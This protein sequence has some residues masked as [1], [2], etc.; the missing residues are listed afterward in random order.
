MFSAVDSCPVPVIARVQGAALGGGTGLAC[1]CDIVLAREDARFGF[2]EVRLGLVP[3]TI[4][5]FALARIGRSQA[6]ALFL[7][8]ELFDAAHALRIGLAHEVHPDDE[9][10]DAAVERVLAAVLRGGPEAVRASKALDRRS[11]RRRSGAAVGARRRADR[12]AARL[13]RGP[14][15]H[16]RVPGAA[17]AR[18]VTPP[19]AC[20]AVACRGEIALRIIRACREVGSQSLALV[21]ADERGGIAEREADAAL[22]VDSYLD[23]ATLA[24][25]AAAGGAQ[26]LHP[27]YG[28]LSE[29]PELAEAC[30][31]AGLVFVGPSSQA[32]ATLGRKDAAREL[33]QRAGV[34]VVPGGAD[35]G[36]I[37][38]PL[39]VKARAGGG[40]RGMRVVREAAQLAE[41][42]EAAAR[43]AGAAFGDRGLVYERYIEGARHVEVQIL[44]DAHGSG[45]HFGE[46]DC[47]VQRRHQK[48]IEEAPAPGVGRELRSELGTAALR[49]A[50]E[51]GYVGAGTAEFLLAPDGS[52]Y[53][54]EMNARIQVE[55]PVTE[56]VTSIDLVR[57]QLEIAA[58]LPLELAQGDVL[59]RGHAIEAR[60]YAEDADNGFL[61][62]A[63]DVLAVRWPR[64]PGVRIDAGVDGG[65]VVGTRYDGL[66]AKLCVH[67]ETRARAL[68][69]L[70]AALDDV[71]VLGLTTNL[72]LLRSVASHPEFERGG[73]DTGWLERTWQPQ[74]AG[75]TP[76]E[77]LAAADAYAAQ[78]AGREPVAGPLARRCACLRG[79]NSRRARRGRRPAR[80]AERARHP[81]RARGA[82]RARAARGARAGCRGGQRRAHRGADAGLGAAARGRRGRRGR[83]AGR[84]ARARGDE[85]GA[86]GVGAVRR[87]RDPPGVPRGAAGG[88]GRPPHRVRR[89]ARRLSV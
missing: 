49:L 25:T 62:T 86:P 89:G 50:D 38:Y 42:T 29:S 39:L 57:R 60:I 11:A 65:D 32:L 24:V 54:L 43:E 4:S 20:V 26:A 27:G 63:G 22:E 9:A 75:A 85:D 81:H 69:R 14:R 51:V 6:R 3:A 44:R 71:V 80:L 79:R 77:A 37:G 64:G 67:G 15:G 48:V 16:R 19:F 46:R 41:A 7:T 72:P 66:L 5:P 78:R 87:S 34:P 84:P 17:G 10:L 88:R 28:F 31:A 76:P 18:L 73:V 23:A 53:F 56:L 82:G 40:G 61:P 52:W 21:A 68:A 30:R 8:G 74:P 55:H 58:G 33:A 59:L 70:N 45:L 12:R 1:C 13:G 35:P 47:S 36:E 2:T 83:G